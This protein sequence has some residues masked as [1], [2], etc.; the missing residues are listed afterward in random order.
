MQQWC[1]SKNG[2]EAEKPCREKQWQPHS[3]HS[4]PSP[5]SPVGALSASTGAEAGGRREAGRP[6]AACQA[7]RHRQ[8][9]QPG[10]GYVSQPALPQASQHEQAGGRPNSGSHSKLQRR[11][12]TSSQAAGRP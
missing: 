3:S 8:E 7:C 12:R 10:V 5:I 6:A 9:G 11:R 4:L 1:A 2:R